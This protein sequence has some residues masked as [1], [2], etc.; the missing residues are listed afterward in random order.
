MTS[1]FSVAVHALV[2]LNHKACMVSSEELA[3]NICTNPARVRKVMA[4]LKKAGLVQTREGVEGGYHFIGDPQ[5]V[6]LRQI[7]EALDMCYVSAAWRSGDTDMDCLVASGMADIMD[8]IYG[9]LDSLCRE[10]LSEFTIKMIDGRIFDPGGKRNPRSDDGAGN[11][12]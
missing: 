12:C 7:G 10:K 2:Y 8:E 3:K 4:R 1:E 6:T 9:K 11:C 5:K